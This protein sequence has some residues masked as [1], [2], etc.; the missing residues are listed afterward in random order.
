[1]KKEQATK[2]HKKHKRRKQLCFLCLFVADSR[3]WERKRSVSLRSLKHGLRQFLQPG[4]V[5]GIDGL[6]TAERRLLWKFMGRRVLSH[7][8]ILAWHETRHLASW[9]FAFLHRLAR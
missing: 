9:A 8:R 5:F 6:W 3:F 7:P 2:R 4:S 1:M